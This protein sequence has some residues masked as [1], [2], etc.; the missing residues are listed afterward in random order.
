VAY[1]TNAIKNSVNHLIRVSVRRGSAEGPGALVLDGCLIHRICED[2]ESVDELVIN[3][4][5]K[6]K[7]KTA[8]KRLT[9]VEQE[10]ITYVYFEEKSLKSYSE[11][12]RI[13]YTT[14]VSK[15][16]SVLKS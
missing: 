2:A 12:K 6:A 4:V 5:S 9:R 3:K 16:K 15:K 8:M 14:A 7:L 10:L 1:A 11:H 13:G